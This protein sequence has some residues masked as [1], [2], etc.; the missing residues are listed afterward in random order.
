[1]PKLA[2]G[3]S[4]AALERDALA[5][6][7]AALAASMGAGGSGGGQIA[8]AAGPTVVGA[9]GGESEP[10]PAATDGAALA[11]SADGQVGGDF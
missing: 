8:S 10:A 6:D 7:A 2:V 5:D 9:N 11:T 4:S 3:S 1:M